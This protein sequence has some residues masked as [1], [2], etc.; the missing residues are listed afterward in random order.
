MPYI[1]IESGALTDV[2]KRELIEKLT[3]AAAETTGI[4]PQFFM[5]AIKELPDA[6]F[7]IGGTT[8]DRIKKE[9]AGK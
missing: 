8:I 7:G 6:S 5:V 3:T 1:S 4:P 2:Q 9:Y